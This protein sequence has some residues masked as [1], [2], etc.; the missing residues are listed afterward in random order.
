M[1][2]VIHKSF[3]GIEN[4]RYDLFTNAAGR[5]GIRVVDG[6][7]EDGHIITNFYPSF[8]KAAKSFSELEVK[9]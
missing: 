9:A 5:S 7:V 6:D 4:I 2:T 8:E 1:K 3:V